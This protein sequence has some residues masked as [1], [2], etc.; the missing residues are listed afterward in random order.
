MF[1]VETVRPAPRRRAAP[2]AAR[3][4]ARPLDPFDLLALAL[5][6]RG[7]RAIPAVSDHALAARL[8][9]DRQTMTRLRA[10]GLLGRERTGRAWPHDAR[11]AARVAALR[12]LMRMGAT[13]DELVAVAEDEGREAQVRAVEL[14]E[15]IEARIADELARRAAFEALLGEHA[16]GR[17]QASGS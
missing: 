6:S 3:V 2:E 17:R 9:I 1:F 7:S 16:A 8:R 15:R 12:D 14:M 11:S 13:L 10:S 5:P 4:E